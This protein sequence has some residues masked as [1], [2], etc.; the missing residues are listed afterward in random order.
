MQH[1][2]MDAESNNLRDF[3]AGYTAAWCS[4][5]PAS[6]AALFSPQGSLRVNDGTPA[7]GREAIAEVARSF[8]SAFPDLHLTMD[9]LIPRGASAE[10]H[11]TLPGTHK[12]ASSRGK[13][14]RISGFELWHLGSDGL[15]TDSQGRFDSAEYQR[16]LAG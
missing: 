15:I 8:M 6:V 4:R 12:G 2:P 7:L 10:F 14:V 3:A 9:D 16:P 13:R 11:W 1:S 5:N